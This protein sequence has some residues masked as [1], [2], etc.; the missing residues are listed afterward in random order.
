[1]SQSEE[2]TIEQENEQLRQLVE[3]SFEM[4]SLL[5]SYIESPSA[6]RREQRSELLEL[7]A[8]YL[9]MLKKMG[10]SEHEILTP[11]N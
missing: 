8:L 9:I 5:K 3:R 7:H 2:M 4:V 10:F 1:M 11:N 6:F